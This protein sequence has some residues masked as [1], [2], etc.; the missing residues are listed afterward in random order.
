MR[1]FA[2][3]CCV[4]IAAVVSLSIPPALRAQENVALGKSATHSSGWDGPGADQFPA[5]NAINGNLGDFQHTGPN[6]FV[7]WWQVDLGDF[8]DISYVVLHNRGG[9]CCQSR[10]RDLTVEILDG[11]DL[12]SMVLF[13]SALINPENVLG[14]GTELGPKFV[15]LD[16]KALTGGSVLGSVVRVTRTPDF[17]FSGT[18]GLGNWGEPYL[19]QLGEVEVFTGDC[20]SLAGSCSSI[21]IAGPASGGPGIY[22]VTATGVGDPIYYTVIADN[23]TDPPSKVGP[24]EESIIPI[25]LSAGTWTVSVK[26]GDS[27]LCPSELPEAL[28]SQQVIVRTCAEDP[29][30]TTCDAMTV[31]PPHGG[32]FPGIYTATATAT[33][34]SLDEVLYTFK[35][36]NGVDPAT[37]LG[38][39]KSPSAAF[40]LGIGSW[41]ITSNVGDSAYC[42]PDDAPAAKCSEV[43]QVKPLTDKQNVAPLGKTKQS[44]GYATAGEG[45]FPS[46]LA[47]DGNRTNFTHTATGDAMA[48]WEVDLLDL[49]AIEAIQMYN[50]SDCCPYRLRDITVTIFDVDGQEVW[51][52]DLLNEDNLHPDGSANPYNPARLTVSLLELTGKA[53][54]GKI[55]RIERTADPDL[56]GA[57]TGGSQDD[58]NVL[59]LG[60]VEIFAAPTVLAASVSRDLAKD[61]FSGD[62]AVDVSL[63][64]TTGAPNTP[65]SVREAIPDGAEATDISDSG[66]VVAG[67]IEWDLGSVSGAETLTYKI[68]PASTC[69]GS[70][71]YGASSFTVLGKKGI[72]K[73]ESLL[74]RAVADV[75]LDIWR[76]LDIGTTGGAAEP[77]AAHDVLVQA[78]GLGIKGTA[79]EFRF[80]HIQQ[81]GDFEFT[82]RIDCMDDPSGAGQAGL[83]VRDTTDSFSAHAFV[84]LS[85]T[86]P[87]A[88]GAGTLK[89]TFRRQTNATRTSGPIPI[90][91]KDMDTLPI[92]LKLKRAGTKLSFERSADGTG[93]TEF[94]TREIGTG[95]TQVDL[96]NDT[97]VGIAATA[98]SAIFARYTFG[99][100][101]G[102]E[103]LPPP[104]PKGFRRG[105]A[106][107][108][109]SLDLTDPVSVLNF[110]FLAG[111]KPACADAADVDDTGTLDLTDAV[112]SLN[113]QFLAG[114]R[115]PDPGP[116][117]CGDDP[118]PDAGDVDLGCE[119]TCQ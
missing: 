7:P 93:F 38:P 116:E 30:D 28:C 19:L 14:G 110:L 89:G 46:S 117:G 104:P 2:R 39:R 68:G 84:G 48:T 57:G 42:P 10:H 22:T 32:S 88:G 27:R 96:K 20:E 45:S 54:D 86:P 17:D 49:Y 21:S 107:A 69:V 76:S 111:V 87:A 85:S 59:S 78:P 4:V 18:G 9:G 43:V 90:T 64:I 98:G 47:I 100:V 15:P 56:S 103:I 40:D 73:G 119:V 102:P 91:L 34:G 81:S 72:V 3:A 58:M 80:L 5:G 53:V 63:S 51:K 24:L 8:Q 92:Y 44:S 115:P 105:D 74:T 75:A 13:K 55:V 23:G 66:Q 25:V 112:Y 97:L 26:V 62:E 16:L 12:D 82:A 108:N 118:T 94:A 95:T 35:A 77:L 31:L 70:L 1:I 99:A 36:D 37:I 67:A 61:T 71:A 101:S 29:Q 60:E 41:T 33:D 65:V 106:D 50:R 11:T 109:G 79:D 6:D 113:F 114:P 52:S 83:M